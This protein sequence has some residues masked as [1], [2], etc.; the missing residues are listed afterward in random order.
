MNVV[1]P[2]LGCQLRSLNLEDTYL[3]VAVW[4]VVCRRPRSF[5]ALITPA[6]RATTACTF[7]TIGTLSTP[8]APPMI[9]GQCI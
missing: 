8:L 3:L 5:L 6:D 7:A 2:V 1:S 9:I 4:T